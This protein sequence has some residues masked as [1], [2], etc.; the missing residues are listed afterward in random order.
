[1][2]KEILLEVMSKASVMRTE[3]SDHANA[4]QSLAANSVPYGMAATI[5]L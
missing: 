4:L 5:S 1:M 2:D 3:M